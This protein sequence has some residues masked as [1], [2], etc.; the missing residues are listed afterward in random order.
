[1]G[2]GWWTL[3]WIG[4]G[5]VAFAQGYFASLEKWEYEGSLCSDGSLD[6][7]YHISFD[8][9]AVDSDLVELLRDQCW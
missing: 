3:N 1:M 2:D 5:D 8:D 4:D 6:L 9:D 7:C